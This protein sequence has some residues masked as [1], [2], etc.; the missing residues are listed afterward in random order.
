[1][2]LARHKN[3]V[4]IN[5]KPHSSSRFGSGTLRAIIVGASC[6]ALLLAFAGLSQS[7]Q[8]QTIRRPLGI[9]AKVDIEDAINSFK[10]PPLTDVEKHFDVHN[11]L[12]DMLSNPAVSGITVSQRWDN[13]QRSDPA[14][15]TDPSGGYDWSYLDDAF[16]Q[17]QAVQKSV[18]LIVTPGVDS[19]PWLLDK[20][21]SCDGILGGGTAPSDC[22]KVTFEGFPEEQR[23]DTHTIPLPWNTV[24]QQAWYDFVAH[25]AARYNSNPFFVSIAVA[26]S[27]CASDEI[28]LPNSLNTDIQPSGLSA[29]ETWKMVIENTFPDSSTSFLHSDQAFIDPWKQAI[30]QY[31]KVFSGITLVISPDSGSDLPNFGHNV[32]PHLDNILYTQDCAV[33]IASTDPGSRLYKDLMSCEAKSEI[34]SYFV[35]AQ[36]SNAK[37]TRVGGLTAS[38]PSTLAV[39]D[40]GIGG[41]KLLTSLSPAPSPPFSAGA[42][43]DH[44]VSGHQDEGCPNPDG[45]CDI[46][47]EE[48]AYN[49]L[50]VF[51]NNTPAAQFY[52]GT[53]GTEHVQYLEVPYVD[54]QYA[55]THGA[56]AKPSAVTGNMSLQDI[57]N[58]AS[59]DL[60]A[61]ADPLF[62]VSVDPSSRTVSAGSSATFTINTD[63]AAGS[64]RP[65]SLS[66]AV[67][68]PDGTVSTSFSPNTVAPGSGSTLTVN[69]TAATRPSALTIKITGAD[70]TTVK[71]EVVTVTVIQGPLV[72]SAT[73]DGAKKLTISGL[74]FGSNPRVMINGTDRS[75]FIVSISDTAILL[76]AKQK[77]LGLVAGDNAI[78]VVD[79]AGTAS[80][81]F[82]LSR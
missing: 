11:L 78:Q 17:A 32:T 72:S 16:A 23:A 5:I 53:V 66:A 60:F 67:T 46:T 14:T 19:P 31:E 65:I 10:P 56:P 62:T 26:G 58:K 45:G 27:I 82:I 42:E 9:Y 71:T 1:M 52:N 47:V 28:I 76:K 49:V 51:F 59:H 61:M 69:T 30:D 2:P 22:G 15:A 13:I 81:I 18:N 77:K 7:T 40:L 48:A 12:S 64:S 3:P 79:A 29:D 4:V 75:S 44:P 8:S 55:E 20:L 54:I 57:L 34:L 6:C 25:L 39:G 35:A 24:Y 68:P 80:N 43:F 21:T 50:T 70:G 38:S 73:F 37:C 74:R 33:S 63:S 41:V 36:G